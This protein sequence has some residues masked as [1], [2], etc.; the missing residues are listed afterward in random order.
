MGVNISND[1]LALLRQMQND[2]NVSKMRSFHHHGTITVFD[3]CTNVVMTSLSIADK[4]SLG[5]KQKEN[6]II[7]GMLHDFFLYDWHEGRIREDGI[8]CWLHPKVALKNASEHFELNR[9]QRNI[10]RSHMFPATLL[11]PPTC[12]EAWIVSA[13]DKICAVKEYYACKKMS[14]VRDPGMSC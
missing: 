5:K 9:Q 10:I 1:E 12:R 6:I 2:M 4:L 11:H 8:H 7:G 13:A 3:H 14:P